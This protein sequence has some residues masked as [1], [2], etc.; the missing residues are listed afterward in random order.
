MKKTVLAFTAMLLG[1]HLFSTGLLAQHF[2]PVDITGDFRT[3]LVLNPQIDGLPLETGDEVGVFD[4]TLCVG[5]AA[6]GTSDT[7]TILAIMQVVLPPPGGTLPGA[8][9]GNAIEFRIWQMSSSTE[10]DA[11]PTFITG[12]LFGD[13]LTV[14]D[15]LVASTSGVG[16]DPYA[17]GPESFQL[18]QNYPNPFNPST[19]IRF[20]LFDRQRIRAIVFD[21]HGN[22][23]RMLVEGLL[24]A[25]E[26]EISWDGRNDRGIRVSSG[27]YIL[28]LESSGAVRQRKLLLVR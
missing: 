3:I 19:S 22:R 27:S 28:R 9:S 24:P 14:V 4:G 15:P 8:V 12:G 10:L 16:V 6:V 18:S 23:V 2:A 20:T 13:P 5:Y 7:L 17:S 26:H 1:M 11:T 21:I 25:G